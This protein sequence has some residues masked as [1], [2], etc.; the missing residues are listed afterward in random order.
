MSNMQ[1]ARASPPAMADVRRPHLS[2][3][4]NAGIDMASIRMAESPDAKKEAVLPGNPAC[5]KRV[6]AYWASVSDKN[7]QRELQHT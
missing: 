3:K 4:I 1:P 5:A 6:G 2:A 7:F